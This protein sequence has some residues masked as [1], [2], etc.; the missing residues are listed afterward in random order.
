MSYDPH[1]EP[2]VA[3]APTHT[4]VWEIIQAVMFVRSIQPIAKKYGYFLTLG[5]GVLNNGSSNHD[6]DIIAGAYTE[7]QEV[8]PNQFTRRLETLMPIR[9]LKTAKHGRHVIASFVYSGNDLPF[10]MWFLDSDLEFNK[11]IPPPLLTGELR[12]E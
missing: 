3:V 11:I 10:E 2:I 6:L 7:E 8:H 12:Q 9:H 1:D 5:G 4:H